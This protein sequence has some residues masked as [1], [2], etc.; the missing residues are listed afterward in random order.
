[1]VQAVRAERT[2]FINHLIDEEQRLHRLV[3][4]AVDENGRHTPPRR[5]VKVVFN[6]DWP[7]DEKPEGLPPHLN[8]RLAIGGAI[9][10]TKGFLERALMEDLVVHDISVG[11]VTVRFR[12]ADDAHTSQVQKAISSL[13][14]NR[15][16]YSVTTVTAHIDGRAIQRK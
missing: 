8:T 12:L 13:W 15:D 3:Y 16:V 11:C 14:E 4:A 6:L 7:A 5:Y 1:M 10:R 9:H 2:D